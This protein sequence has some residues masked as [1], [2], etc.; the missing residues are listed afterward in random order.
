MKWFCKSFNQMS[1]REVFDSLRLREQVFTIGQNCP[2]PDI[3]DIDLNSMHL[4]AYDQDNLV[5]YLRIY[6]KNQ[7]KNLG[8]VVVSPDFQGRGYGRELIKQA[9]CYLNQHHSNQQIQ[10]SAQHYLER[11]YQSLGF[12]S[13]GAIYKEAGIDHIFMQFA[14]NYSQLVADE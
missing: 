9:L 5:A 1:G 11:F 3:D 6:D 2:D 14:D 8:R 7:A 10:I 4:F 13:F 12:V